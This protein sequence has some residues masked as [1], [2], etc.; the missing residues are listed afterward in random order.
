MNIWNF[1]ENKLSE[2]KSL[3]LMIVIEIHG[4]SPGK[5][6]FSMAVSNGGELYG[7]IGGGSMEFKLVEQRKEL[8]LF[9]WTYQ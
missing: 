9:C 6:G 7:S 3:Y 2:G 4:S 1:I 5:Q 8:I